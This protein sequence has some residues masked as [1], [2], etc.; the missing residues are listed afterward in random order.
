[1]AGTFPGVMPALIDLVQWIRQ[2]ALVIN[3]LRKGDVNSTTSLTLTASTTTTV[4]TDPNLTPAKWLDF[5]PLT[6][7]AAT[8]KANGTIYVLS[9]DRGNGSFTVTHASNSQTDRTFRVLI[10]GG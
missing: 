7:N 2:A 4:L 8:E 6:A 9:A 3:S 1:M 10:M 5:D